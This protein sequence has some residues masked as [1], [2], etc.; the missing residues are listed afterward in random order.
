MCMLKIEKNN[1]AF[2]NILP[3]DF[4]TSYSIEIDVFIYSGLIYLFMNINNT[5][6][7]KTCNTVYYYS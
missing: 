7:Y 4:N 5:L 3:A 2:Q 6:M 1:V